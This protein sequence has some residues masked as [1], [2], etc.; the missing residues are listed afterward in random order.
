[1]IN[2]G[3]KLLCYLAQ[4]YFVHGLRRNRDG[5]SAPLFSCFTLFTYKRICAAP[6]L[7]LQLQCKIGLRRVGDAAMNRIHGG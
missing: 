3:L 4:S 6:V 7:R 1:M 5:R 2:A